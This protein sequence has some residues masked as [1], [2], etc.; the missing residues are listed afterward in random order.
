[1]SERE[2]WE[3]PFWFERRGEGEEKRRQLENNTTKNLLIT[4]K[5]LE[6]S[7]LTK[8][9]LTTIG[10]ESNQSDIK[11]IEDYLYQEK[12]KRLKHRENLILVG[13]SYHNDFSRDEIDYLEGNFDDKQPDCAIVYR[14]ESGNKVTVV[15]EIKT[16]RDDLE[17]Q[18]ISKYISGL[19]LDPDTNFYLADWSKIYKTFKKQL[20]N[21]DYLEHRGRYLLKNF[22]KYLEIEEMV[23]FQGYDLS[24][25]FLELVL[26]YDHEEHKKFLTKTEDLIREIKSQVKNSEW[27]DTENWTIED[28]KRAWQGQPREYHVRLWKDSWYKGGNNIRFEFELGLEVGREM[29][30]NGEFIFSLHFPTSNP[31]IYS[32]NQEFAET[33]L[34]KMKECNLKQELEELDYRIHDSLFEN[35]W[36]NDTG[37]LSYKIPFLREDGDAII[38]ECAKRIEEIRRS[39]LLEIIDKTLAEY[40]N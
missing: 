29:A 39:G 10:V 9:L 38:R 8:K 25:E 33:L 17:K 6:K 37:F 2:A 30:S 27:F 16:G 4:L 3:N 35:I 32:N 26:N 15:I 1:M 24:E 11:K 20:Q 12:I 28:K 13:L 5:D 36:G 7:D 31:Y 14:K 19:D 18:Q 22:L 34:E 40:K 21:S 23:P